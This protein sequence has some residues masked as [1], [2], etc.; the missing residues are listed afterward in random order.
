MSEINLRS[1]FWPFH[2]DTEIF[3][4]EILDK[5]AAV[6]HFGCPKITFDRISESYF[7]SIGQF[8]C[9]KFMFD[10]ISRYF[11]LIQ[12]FLYFFKFLS[13]WPP[14]AILDGTTM[15]IIKLVRDIWMSNAC[16]KFEEHSLNP[17][18]V[19]ALIPKLGRGGGGG[20]CV[21]DE[22][23]IF[24]KILVFREYNK[25]PNPTHKY[26]FFHNP[27]ILSWK[28]LSHR[29]CAVIPGIAL[30]QIYSIKEAIHQSN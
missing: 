6:G 15:S 24:P 27:T 22:N 3:L 1:H 21:A 26:I 25:E 5:M 28:N 11:R 16:V 17:S 7:R 20:G 14:A 23:I 4:V 10:R 12:N 13:K 18:K 29:P 19:I 8:G 9:P 2:I 30:S